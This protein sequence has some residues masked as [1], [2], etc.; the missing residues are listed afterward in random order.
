MQKS[1]V[2]DNKVTLVE[3]VI[4]MDSPSE[5]S[6]STQEGSTQRLMRGRVQSS[7]GASL[8][9][10][11]KTNATVRQP[12]RFYTSS[13]VSDAPITVTDFHGAILVVGRVSNTSFTP[14]AS[15]FRIRKI[16]IWNAPNLGSSEIAWLASDIA[17][18]KDETTN[19]GTPSGSVS[20]SK[21]VFTPPKGSVAFDWIYTT[22]TGSTQIF[23]ISAPQGSIIDFDVEW[24]LSTGHLTM[25]AI[26]SISGSVTVGAFYRLYMDRSTGN[27]YIRPLAFAANS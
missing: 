24:T 27:G 26:N 13:A 21:N 9:P 14:I 7:G 4:D 19:A 23:R 18:V 8:P 2:T 1:N 15:S 11:I 12:I 16:T 10:E 17:R 3:R 6:S 5:T 22:L 20:T 25:S